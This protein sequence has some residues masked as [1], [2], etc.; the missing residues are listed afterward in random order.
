[1]II[2]YGGGVNVEVPFTTLE[3]IQFKKEFVADGGTP[4]AEATLKAID[5]VKNLYK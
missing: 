5:E 2:T 4:M 3:N 1:M